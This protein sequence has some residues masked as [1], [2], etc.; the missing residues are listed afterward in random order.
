M[1]VDRRRWLVAWGT[2][3]VGAVAFVAVAGWSV[4]WHPVP[5][6][7]PPAV[8]AESLF[9]S[10]QIDRA[11]SFAAWARLWSWSSLALSVAVGW[12][13]G[14]SRRGQRLATWP[15]GPRWLRII[16]IV[17]VVTLIGRLVTLPLAIAHRTL[18]LDAGLA[19]SSWVAWVIDLVKS[20]LLAG[21][22]TSLALLLLAACVRRFPTWWP[23]VAGMLL[24]AL[25]FVGSFVYPL[26]VEPLFNS[27][28]PLPEGQLRSDIL[29]VAA[30]EDV[31][32]DDVL[33]ADASRRTTTLNAYVSGLGSSRRVVLYD[34]LVDEVPEE[35][36][37]SVVAHELAHAKY[38][39][40][41]TGTS[42]GAAGGFAGI[43]LLALAGLVR[44][45]RGRRGWASPDAVPA[46]LAVVAVGSVLVLPVQNGISRQIET[47]ADVVALR[48]TGD[49]AAFIELQRQLA[50][51]SLAD[52]TPPGWSQWWFGSHPTVLE[53]AATAGEKLQRE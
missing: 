48:T 2:V 52:P 12:C 23:V 31:K 49:P 39:D 7:R 24:A 9:T 25:T 8:P 5:G 14:F 50:L 1:N 33:V 19:T 18:L 26:T 29:A 3:A 15:R 11:E 32:I 44:E 42:L 43:G 34:N 28:Q 10:A 35:Q 51:R 13:L 53:R 4:P 41:L 45:R 21:A 30:D 20:E 22:V 17:M 36:V 37:L 38:D 16:Q 46:L 6:G 40:V 27:F 47:R